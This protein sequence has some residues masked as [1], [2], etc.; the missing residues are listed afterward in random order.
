MEIWKK[1]EGFEFYQ[2]SNFGKVMSLPH[3]DNRG[4]LV[5]GKILGNRLTDR[6]YCT[7]VL[8]DN[9]KQNSFKLHRLVANSFIYNEFNK[10]D[11]NHKDGIK[12]N[13]HFENLEWVTKSEN[14]KHAFKTGLNK[15]SC[16]R[17]KNGQFIKNGKASYVNI[18]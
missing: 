7:V 11:V 12:S 14:A 15:T 13:N 8:Y 10:P 16:K 17:N 5:K 18:T 3:I 4:R 6:G 9:G 1:I 2:V